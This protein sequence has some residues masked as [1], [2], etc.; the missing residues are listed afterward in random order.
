[1]NLYLNTAKYQLA[2]SIFKPTTQPSNGKT[3]L[4]CSAMGVPQRFYADFAEYLC[5]LGFIVYTF[6][7]YGMGFSAPTSI[8]NLD[9]NLQTW[10]TDIEEML[11]FINQQHSGQP[12]YAI[13]HSVGGQLMGQVA[14]NRLISKLIL[15][16]SQGGYWK[17]WSGFDKL[18]VF[19]FWHLLIPPF[20]WVCGY[21]PAKKLGLFENLPK[22]VAL[23][24]AQWGRSPQYF[25]DFVD[26]KGYDSLHIPLLSLGFTDDFFAPPHAWAWLNNQYK[27]CQLTAHSYKPKQLELSKIGH[28]D[29]FKLKMKPYFWQTISDFII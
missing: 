28:F 3:V 20:S 4:I 19:L 24:W 7:Y 15:I 17:F 21:F 9:T 25:A 18:K 23:Q 13:C 14:N 22:Y 6:D 5:G 2:Y 10:A 29:M 12:I 16:A 27:N 11:N 1:M 26:T 8:K